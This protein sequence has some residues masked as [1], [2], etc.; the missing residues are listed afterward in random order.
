MYTRSLLELI[1][2]H[3]PKENAEFYSIMHICFGHVYFL[4]QDN[5]KTIQHYKEAL[6]YLMLVE[7]ID[8]SRIAIVQSNLAIVTEPNDSFD[9]QMSYARIISVFKH[10]NPNHVKDGDRLTFFAFYYDTC[11]RTKRFDEAQR[12]LTQWAEIDYEPYSREQ[13]QFFSYTMQF[14]YVQQQYDEAIAHGI[15]ILETFDH[16]KNTSI[17]L[18]VYDMLIDCYRQLGDTVSAARRQQEHDDLYAQFTAQR[19]AIDDQ[20]PVNTA[21]FLPNSTP[22]PHITKQMDTLSS[23]YIVVVFDLS[24]NDD[25]VQVEQLQRIHTQFMQQFEPRLLYVTALKNSQSLYVIRGEDDTIYDQLL[26]LKSSLAF[27]VTFGYCTSTDAPDFTFEQR[28]Q[29]CY[30]HIYY[31]YSKKKLRNA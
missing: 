5:D 9:T 28:M 2:P 6:S 8:I 21:S 27:P 18:Y 15:R 26:Q 1:M 22:L 19:Q 4:L 20:F 14:H 23:P 30:A 16:A 29:M 7:P 31:A 17:I 13:L 3:V 24:S 25:A 10:M 11:I 12:I